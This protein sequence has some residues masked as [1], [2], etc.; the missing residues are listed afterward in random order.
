MLAVAS[1]AGVLWVCSAAVACY[2]EVLWLLLR[3][4]S[5]REA[6]GEGQ[7]RGVGVPLSNCSYQTVEN[8]QAY[9]H[10]AYGQ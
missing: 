8:H 2:A 7:W 1:F 9:G 4:L 6:L 5:L 3:G 10:V